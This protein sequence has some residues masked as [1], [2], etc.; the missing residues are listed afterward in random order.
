MSTVV[1]KRPGESDE[2]LISR[3]RRQIQAERLLIRLK[4][5]Q[6]HKSR[7]EAKA[8]KMAPV[9]RAKRRGSRR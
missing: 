1:K 8:E 6:F 9:R 3:F 7:S 2:S 5:Q 4:E